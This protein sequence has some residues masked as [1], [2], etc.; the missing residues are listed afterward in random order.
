MESGKYLAFDI[1]EKGITRKILASMDSPPINDSI[2]SLEFSLEGNVFIGANGRGKT[3]ILKSLASAPYNGHLL[4]KTNLDKK[5]YHQY[6][7]SGTVLLLDKK[8]N[9]EFKSIKSKDIVYICSGHYKAIK[10]TCDVV[11]ID[12]M[13]EVA[14]KLKF[15]YE[16][17]YV[18]YW[19]MSTHE[20]DMAFLH[21]RFADSPE[22][23]DI[24]ATPKPGNIE[25]SETFNYW[26]FCPFATAGQIGMFKDHRY[27]PMWDEVDYRKLINMSHGE[28]NINVLKRYLE[29][30]RELEPRKK[31]PILAFDEVDAGLAP[32]YQKNVAELLEKLVDQERVQLFFSTHSPLVMQEIPS[33][34][35]VFN[36]NS[37]PLQ[38]YKRG[39]LKREDIFSIMGY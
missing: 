6:D 32:Q 1:E 33:S 16:A 19:D 4:F 11:I 15:D 30:S 36:L 3:H 27:T 22:R 38:I 14:R 35:R 29:K 23:F 28:F 24:L 31:S 18:S 7:I 12:G 39:E 8:D 21:R 17:P 26:K 2:K 20:K 5:R 37:S 34:W 9:N 10:D 25:I 13:P